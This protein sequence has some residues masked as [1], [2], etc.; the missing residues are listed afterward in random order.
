MHI[1]FHVSETR[2]RGQ[3]CYAE[4]LSG[5]YRTLAGNSATANCRGNSRNTVCQYGI[6]AFCGNVN[7]Q[8][9]LLSLLIRGIRSSRFLLLRGLMAPHRKDGCIIRGG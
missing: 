8:F 5:G 3:S 6:E 9:C 7:C 4:T 2:A 1:A